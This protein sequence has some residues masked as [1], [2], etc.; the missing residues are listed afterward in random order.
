VPT[1]LIVN[2]DDLGYDPSIDQG[3]LEAHAH[4]IVTAASAMVDTPFADSAVAEAPATLDLGLHVVVPAGCGEAQLRREIAR[5]IAR[6]RA[7]R[8]AGPTHLDS[9]RHVHAAPAALRVFA[10]ASREEGIPLR[11]LDAV[12]R[13]TLRLQGVATADAFLGD[14]ALRPCWTRERLVAALEALPDGIVELMCHPGHVPTHV[15]TSFAGEREVE[16]A[17]VCDPAA[18]AAL[19][20][21]GAS[22]RQ[23]AGVFPDQIKSP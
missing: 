17:A 21:S 5:Q 16:L 3:I 23:F 1:L 19:T 11:A 13:E 20:K 22:L 8:G 15:R 14:A 9:H 10:E 7:L 2:A 12:M 6:F 18:R 4:G